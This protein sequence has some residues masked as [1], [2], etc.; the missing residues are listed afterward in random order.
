[1]AFA[2]KTTADKASASAAGKTTAAAAKTPRVK[3]TYPA[4]FGFKP[5]TVEMN[6]FT[7]NEGLVSNKYAVKFL[8]GSAKNPKLAVFSEDISFFDNKES[9]NSCYIPEKNKSE[10]A[11]AAAMTML[12]LFTAATFAVNPARRLPKNRRYTV[13]MRVNVR[14][15]NTVAVSIREIAKY[16]KNAAGKMTATALDRKE[17]EFKKLRKAAKYLPAAFQNICITN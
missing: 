3:Q 6:I 8:R 11:N 2:K 5:M 7:N 1:M 17:D 15:D 9:F 13:K 12:Q 16:N 10:G 4:K 14:K